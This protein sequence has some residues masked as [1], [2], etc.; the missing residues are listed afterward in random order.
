MFV[1]VVDDV[2]GVL[3]FF[4]VVVIVVDFIES[5]VNV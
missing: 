2:F 3:I 1:I 5:S 4:D